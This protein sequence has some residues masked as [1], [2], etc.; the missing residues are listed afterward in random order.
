MNYY[1][2]PQW[3]NPT[4]LCSAKKPDAKEHTLLDSIMFKTRWKQSM[5]VEV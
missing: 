5:V 4:G 1:Y 3:I 2:M